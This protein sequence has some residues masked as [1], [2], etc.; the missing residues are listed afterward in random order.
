MDST[1]SVVAS[2][3]GVVTFL[4]TDVV[5]STGLSQRS[6][7]AGKAL[8]RQAELIAA[9]IDDHGGVRPPDQGEGDSTLSV[10]ARP[11]AALA[12]A[13]AAQR[14]LLAE[15]WPDGASVSVRMAVHTGEAELAGNGNYAGLALI[16]SARLRGLARGGQ[17]LVSGATAALVSDSLP[18]GA[19]LADLGSAALPGFERPEQVHQLCHAELP[20]QPRRLGLL[21]SPLQGTLASWATSLVGRVRERREVG[22]LLAKGRLVTITGAGGSGKTRLA[23]A[24]GQDRMDRHPDG[25]VWV[26]LALVPDGAQVTAAVVAACG[27]IETPGASALEVLTHRLAKTDIL[28]VL[29]NCEHLLATCAE[30]A[31]ALLRAGPEV[32]LLA[33]A[34]EPLGV[35]GEVTWRIP[36]LSVPAEDERSLERIAATE[37]VQLFVERARASQPDFAL[38]HANAPRDSSA[39]SKRRVSSVSAC[40]KSWAR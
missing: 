21:R 38:D 2:P 36:S 5:A 28:I 34:R 9:A 13:L 20:L 1:G 10:F 37:A 8:A 16:R 33:T 14:A 18:E 39:R 29:D 6:P 27:L 3:A 19:S 24:V 25:V 35:A 31:D 17:V 15:P 30:L 7:L 11:G 12:T 40:W 23:Y 26:E 22:E 4:L 32:R